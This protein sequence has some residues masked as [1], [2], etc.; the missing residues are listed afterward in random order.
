MPTIKKRINLTTDADIEVAL[1]NAAKRDG[2]P[3]TTKATELLRLA[4]HL[5]EDIILGALAASRDDQKVKYLTHEKVW[6]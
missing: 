5:E 2:L 1:V 6:H 4:L 3:V